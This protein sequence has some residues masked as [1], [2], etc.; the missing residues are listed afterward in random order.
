MP[1]QV[2]QAEDGAPPLGAYSLGWKAGGFVFTTGTV[3]IDKEGHLAGDT[4]EEQTNQAIDNLLAILTAGGATLAD[5]VKV[6]VHLKDPSQFASY[7]EV[8]KQRF[9]PPYPA[10]T[11]V[12]SDLSLMPGMLIEMDAVAYVG[13]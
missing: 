12:G 8:Y 11:T 13:D 7:N 6:N 9:S 10:R 5:V 2:I 3:P 4:I 1:K